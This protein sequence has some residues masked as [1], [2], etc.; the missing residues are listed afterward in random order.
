MSE[1]LQTVFEAVNTLVNCVK[2]CPLRGKQFANLCD[3]VEAEPTALLRYCETHRL[4]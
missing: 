1:E 3:D 4:V 2:K